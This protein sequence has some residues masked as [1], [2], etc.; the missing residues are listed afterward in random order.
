MKW[1]CIWWGGWLAIGLAWSGPAG[2]VF[3]L[4]APASGT[5]LLRNAGFEQA[6]AGRFSD[7]SLA[8]QG[9]RVAAGEGR[10]GSPPPRAKPPIW[11]TCGG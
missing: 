10:H 4:A 2:P 6:S 1:R 8:P 9:C 5:N 3:R 7:W 11:E